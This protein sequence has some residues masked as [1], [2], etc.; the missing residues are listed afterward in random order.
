MSE[1]LPSEGVYED[2]EALP[3]EKK[4]ETLSLSGNLVLEEGYDDAEDPEE[5]CGEETEEMEQQSHC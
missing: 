5:D 4:E 2:I 3:V 1:H